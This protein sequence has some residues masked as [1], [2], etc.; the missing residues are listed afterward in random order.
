VRSDLVKDFNGYAGGKPFFGK[1]RMPLQAD[2]GV[3]TVEISVGETT[4][5]GVINVR[6]DPL[7][8]N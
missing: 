4:E 7:T 3:Y 1:K 5:K 2:A 6:Q 8:N